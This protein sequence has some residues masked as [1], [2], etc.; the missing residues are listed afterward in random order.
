MTKLIAKHKL[1]LDFYQLECG[2]FFYRMFNG[3]DVKIC[4]NYQF[5]VR[6]IRIFFY[7]HYQINN[8]EGAEMGE[9]QLTHIQHGGK[10]HMV[11]VGE[12]PITHRRAVASALI[13]MAAAP[14]SLLKEND[15]KKGDALS[16]AKIA[17]IMAAKKTAELIPLCHPVFLSKIE[18]ELSI[19][20]NGVLIQST[21]VCD[22]KT[23]VEMEA[24]TACSIAALTI[25]DMCKAVDKKMVIGEIKLLH[26]SGGKSGAYNLK[27]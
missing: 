9:K 25:Y 10:L 8:Q 18:I 15:L 17:G 19:V 12:K 2:N 26:K 11:D 27:K 3:F 24:L 4:L 23:G 14:L 1:I 22:G 13:Q 21:A 20:E 16:T 6:R 7:K 5:V